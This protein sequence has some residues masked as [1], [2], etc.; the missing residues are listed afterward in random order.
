MAFPRN[1]NQLCTPSFVYFILSVVG[2]IITIFQNMGHTN[3][4]CLGSLTCNVPST[5][6]I[7]I[8]KV[9]YILFWTWILNLMCKDGYTNIAWFLVLLPF[10]LLFWIVGMVA[11]NQMKNKK[12]HMMNA[13]GGNPHPG[14]EGILQHTMD[15]FSLIEGHGRRPPKKWLRRI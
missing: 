13:P 3:I 12:E 10:V 14:Q 4:Y 2:I 7:F 9:V 5:I 11:I 15:A 6:M 8:I 1:I